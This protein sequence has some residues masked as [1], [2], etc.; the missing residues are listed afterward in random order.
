MPPKLSRQMRQI[1][2]WL[3]DRSQVEGQEWVSFSAAEF[4][5]IEPEAVSRSMLNS[6]LR[7]VERL[8]TK[9]SGLVRRRKG[10]GAGFDGRPLML[11]LTAGGLRAVEALQAPRNAPDK[12]VAPVFY[13]AQ[14]A[15][16]ILL[17]IFKLALHKYRGRRPYETHEQW[18]S[19]KA[20]LEANLERRRDRLTALDGKCPE[21]VASAQANFLGAITHIYPEMLAADMYLQDEVELAARYETLLFKQLEA[22][23]L[24]ASSY[25]LSLSQQNEGKPQSFGSKSK[26]LLSHLE[27][28]F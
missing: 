15:D 4:L 7:S 14:E 6:V 23:G 16:M 5:G 20:S 8:E 19:R 3:Y 12:S 11:R 26:R 13:L 1:L 22:A 24:D 25:E 17:D 28:P 10:A 2:E 27:I 18:E 9:A 21:A